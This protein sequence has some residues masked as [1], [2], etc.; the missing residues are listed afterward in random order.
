MIDMRASRAVHLLNAYFDD[1]IDLIFRQAV[2]YLN[3]FVNQVRGAKHK[4]IKRTIVNCL[5]NNIPGFS[6]LYSEMFNRLIT[7]AMASYRNNLVAQLDKP[8]VGVV[9]QLVKVF[10]FGEVDETV[11]KAAA[12][13]TAGELARQEKLKGILDVLFVQRC[14]TSWPSF[15]MELMAVINGPDSMAHTLMKDMIREFFPPFDAELK[16]HLATLN[17]SLRCPNINRL[18][19]NIPK[20]KC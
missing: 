9:Q 17:V 6:S 11:V 15:E 20:G 18:S 4:E 3:E 2:C 7:A 14:F 1:A 16:R 13:G 12:G 19:A 10:N 5:K 8:S